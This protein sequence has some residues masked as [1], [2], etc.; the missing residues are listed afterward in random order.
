MRRGMIGLHAFGIDCENSRR[1]FTTPNWPV[2]AREWPCPFASEFG[3][4]IWKSFFSPANWVLG[5]RIF[6]MFLSIRFFASHLR[7]W[8][9][10]VLTICFTFRPEFYV[11]SIFLGVF[12]HHIFIESPFR[13]MELFRKQIRSLCLV[14]V[15]WL[16]CLIGRLSV[17]KKIFTLVCLLVR[18]T[19]PWWCQIHLLSYWFRGFNLCFYSCWFSFNKLQNWRCL[20]RLFLFYLLAVRDLNRIKVGGSALSRV[21]NT[22]RGVKKEESVWTEGRIRKEW[23]EAGIQGGW[24]TGGE[25]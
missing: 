12:Q 8:Y 6:R 15:N 1:F 4:G 9:K 24:E 17:A 20:V 11:C 3:H 19:A 18:L 10:Q 22:G 25:S 13:L 14:F 2:R 16:W 23:M 21:S 5:I 7:M